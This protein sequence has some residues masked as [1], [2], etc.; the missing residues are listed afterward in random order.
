MLPQGAEEPQGNRQP[1][2]NAP[3]LRLP[4]EG[5]AAAAGPGDGLLRSGSSRGLVLTAERLDTR[6]PLGPVGRGGAAE[7]GEGSGNTHSK[8]A[9]QRILQGHAER[10]RYNKRPAVIAPQDRAWWLWGTP[11][12]EPR[13]SAEP[14]AP[15]VVPGAGV[16]SCATGSVQHTARTAGGG[17]GVCQGRPNHWHGVRL[18]HPP[19]L[20]CLHTVFPW[21]SLLPAGGTYLQSAPWMLSL[22]QLAL[23]GWPHSS[24][25]PAS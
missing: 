12:V 15:L 7:G 25:S 5:V 9:D 16:A 17:G 6:P 21:L 18:V 8:P 24:G 3:G 11:V 10:F 4:V 22:A 14:R 19:P 1:P 13:F 23:P 2:T 20:Q